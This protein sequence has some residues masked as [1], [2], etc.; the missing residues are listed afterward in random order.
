MTIFIA[1]LSLFILA[2]IAPFINA[3]FPRFFRMDFIFYF[4]QLYFL[5]LMGLIPGVAVGDFHDFILPWLPELGFSLM[6]RLDGLVADFCVARH[7]NRC[8]DNDLCGLLYA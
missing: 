7:R 4:R 5:W 6:F 3:G 2:M 8:F 1:I